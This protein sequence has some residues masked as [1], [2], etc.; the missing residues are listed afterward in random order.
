MKKFKKRLYMSRGC[1][2]QKTEVPCVPRI[3]WQQS[4]IFDCKSSNYFST[5]TELKAQ[6][7]FHYYG[8]VNTHQFYASLLRITMY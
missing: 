5:L 1:C 8:D 7:K 3:T 2:Q 6:A 4:A